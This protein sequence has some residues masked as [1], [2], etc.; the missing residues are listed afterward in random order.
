MLTGAITSGV[1]ARLGPHARE[2]PLG[3]GAG[4]ITRKN[5][6]PP[7]LNA[8]TSMSQLTLEHVP[9]QPIKLTGPRRTEG[10]YILKGLTTSQAYL[11]RHPK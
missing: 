4:C 6:Q 11:W 5:S 9:G 3:V 8:E 2:N 1:S 10:G 7:R